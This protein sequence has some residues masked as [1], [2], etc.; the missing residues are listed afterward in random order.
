MSGPAADSGDPLPQPDE[1]TWATLDL[2][3]MTWRLSMPTAWSTPLVEG[4][5]ALARAVR[6]G[7]LGHRRGRKLGPLLVD[8]AATLAAEEATDDRMG[9]LPDELGELA[10]AARVADDENSSTW[11]QLAEAVADKLASETGR[12]VVAATDGSF[13]LRLSTDFVALVVDLSEQVD[14]LT[15]EGHRSL[16]R[17]SPT[18]YPDDPE[19]SAGYAALAGAELVERRLTAARQL[20]DALA[21]GRVERSG[22]GAIMRSVNS[23]RLVLSSELGIEDDDHRPPSPLSSSFATY[24]AYEYLGQFL[25]DLVAAARSTLND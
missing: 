12:S 15:S 2:E 5:H 10:E 9:S 18:A 1:S 22:I 4:L 23:L 17:L 8:V 20:R 16:A 25:F 6:E 19:R 7:R 14:E 3:R 24:L 11:P 21:A 13:L